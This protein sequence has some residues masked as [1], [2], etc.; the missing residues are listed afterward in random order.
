ML[1]MRDMG[2][3]TINAGVFLKRLRLIILNYNFDYWHNI[4]K[5]LCSTRFQNSIH[6]QLV[7]RRFFVKKCVLNLKN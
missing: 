3:F 1:Y 7:V 5:D 6:H 2:K 4:Q